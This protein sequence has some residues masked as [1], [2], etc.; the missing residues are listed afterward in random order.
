LDQVVN[1][2]FGDG[3]ETAE[4]DPKLGDD[5][6]DPE[7][8]DSE[9]SED[10]AAAFWSSLTTEEYELAEDDE[11]ARERLWNAWL[12]AN[13]SGDDAA[14]E[15]DA[16][17]ERADEPKPAND[18]PAPTTG[19][20]F[21]EYVIANADQIRDEFGMSVPQYLSAMIGASDREWAAAAKA[22]GVP[23]SARPTHA[24]L[25]GFG[26][27]ASGAVFAEDWKRDLERMRERGRYLGQ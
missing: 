24:T 12:D 9:V 6:Q 25:R 23:V 1:E 15:A 16:G 20:A 13:E 5:E 19:A 10:D 3:D 11:G 27:R 18:G 8:D 26:Y 2:F 14:D 22:A 21:V 7:T 17:D 4:E